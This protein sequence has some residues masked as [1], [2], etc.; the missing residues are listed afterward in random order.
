MS[1]TSI[2]LIIL[3]AL[4]AIV[5]ASFQYFYKVKK[6]AKITYILA[7]LKALALLL[8]LVLLINPKIKTV[9]TTDTKPILSVLADNSS[10]ITHFKQEQN[11]TQ[12]VDQITNDSDLNNKFTIKQY[13][14]GSSLQVNDSLNFKQTNTNISKALKENNSIHKKSTNPTLLFT[15][16]NQT[17]GDSYEY[18]SV[19]NEVY[20]IVFGDTTQYQDIRISHLNVNKYSYLENKFP[21]EA[22]LFYDGKQDISVNYSIR[23]KGKTIFSKK[24]NFSE[25]ETTHTVNTHLNTNEK[26]VQYYTALVTTLKNEKNTVNNYKSFSV[27]VIDEQQKG[28]IISTI[29]HPDLGALK[30]AIESDKQRKV[31]IITDL[32]EVFAFDKYQFFIFYQPNNYFKKFFNKI[33]SNYLVIT[34]ANTDW[35]FINSQNLGISKRAIH[36]TEYYE[37]VF[38][39]DFTT[40]QQKDINFSNFPPLVDKFG[41]VELTTEHQI[42]LQQRYAGVTSKEPLLVSIEK[43]SHKSFFLLGEGLWKWR[44][45]SFRNEDTFESFDNF[46]GNLIQYI[47]SNKKRKRL[48]VDY[49][50]SYNANVPIVIN[51][52]Y[53]DKNYLFDNRANLS[54]TLTNT[55]T[56]IAKEFPMT[57]FTNSYQAYLEGISPGEYTFKVNVNGQNL[58]SYG[59]FKVNTYNVEQQFTNANTKKLQQLATNTKAKLFYPSQ[60][61]SLKQELLTNNNYKTIQTST[62]TE[63]NLINWYWLLIIVI[64]LLSIEWFIRKYYGKI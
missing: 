50:N 54:L 15:D 31:D 60:F 56:K 43:N 59:K 57:L 24:L 20:P 19:K 38:N 62:T 4:I 32:N 25:S 64:G 2:S 10:S 55:A 42:L 29:M 33:K 8:L 40:F 58:N 1:T 17:I 18:T 46:T 21:V 37:A 13:S 39:T 23:H 53:L 14:F 36:Q 5:L 45:A 52:L 16:G 3:S 41:N 49:K 51:A 61:N 35:N 26:G 28:A 7:T 47:A 34:G 44:A 30:R 48:T 63:K 9:A 27:E 22:L 6:I 11:L 12:L